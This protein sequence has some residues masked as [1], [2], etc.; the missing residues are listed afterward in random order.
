MKERNPYVWLGLAVLL[1]CFPFSLPALCVL[2]R[3]DLRI[4]IT[5]PPAIFWDEQLGMSLNL[6]PA[7][8]TVQR[9]TRRFGSHLAMRR[10]LRGIFAWNRVGMQPPVAFPP[11]STQR[12]LDASNQL[13]HGLFEAKQVWKEM[14]GVVLSNWRLMFSSSCR[15][16]DIWKVGWRH[17]SVLK[18]AASGSLWRSSHQISKH[19]LFLRAWTLA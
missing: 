18:K 9:E 6:P 5:W 15:G 13:W 2:F 3:V 7:L 17:Q 14:V 11:Y 8:S 10:L 12:S 19:I 4:G 16:G 1:F